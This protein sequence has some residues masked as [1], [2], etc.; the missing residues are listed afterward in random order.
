MDPRGTP[1]SL[2]GFFPPFPL[3]V[4]TVPGDGATGG[5]LDV[6]GGD[7]L[8]LIDQPV[9]NHLC[10]EHGNGKHPEGYTDQDLRQQA[11]CG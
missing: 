7:Q 9:L 6:D 10:G 4:D 8:V 5:S 11:A 3:H 1:G 2:P